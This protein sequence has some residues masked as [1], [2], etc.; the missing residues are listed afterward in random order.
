MPPHHQ[1]QDNRSYPNY[2]LC[3]HARRVTDNL[4]HMKN[5]L[6]EKPQALPFVQMIGYVEGPVPADEI[7][8]TTD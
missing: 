7:R 1:G 4:L 2:N 3:D 5:L 6:V 8:A